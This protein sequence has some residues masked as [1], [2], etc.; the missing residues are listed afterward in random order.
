[1][2]NIETKVQT[3]LEMQIEKLQNEMKTLKAKLKE[4][5]EQS[6]D[7][8]KFK[9]SDGKEVET[10]GVLYYYYTKPGGKFGLKKATLCTKI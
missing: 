7:K 8:I 5:K 9:D 1:M 6:G 3:E 2:S 4:T 10:T